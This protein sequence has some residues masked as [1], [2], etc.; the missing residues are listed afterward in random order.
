MDSGGRAI[1]WRAEAWL[2]RDFFHHRSFLRGM[3]HQLSF[4]LKDQER[5]W[6]EECNHVR[7]Y[8]DDHFKFWARSGISMPG[9]HLLFLLFNDFEI[10]SRAG[11]WYHLVLFLH[12]HNRLV[13]RWPP[14][15]HELYWALCGPWIRVRPLLRRGSV[16][17][18]SLRKNHVLFRLHD[19][20]GNG[21]L[22]LPDAK[23]T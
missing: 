23:A 19:P 14:Q 16:P 5:S 9:P 20:R 6:V 3:Y 10:L 1:T 12:D 22:L 11:K 7:I 15:V 2:Q 21:G 4:Q 13:Q 8:R 18:P 17:I